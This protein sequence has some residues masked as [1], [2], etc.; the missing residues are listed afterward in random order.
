MAVQRTDHGAI[1]FRA[2]P[3]LAPVQGSFPLLADA[4][5]TTTH[6]HTYTSTSTL[7]TT[8]LIPYPTSSRLSHSPT[9]HG[10]IA[11]RSS[12][13]NLSFSGRRKNSEPTPPTAFY[14]STAKPPHH[15]RNLTSPSPAA[16]T[17]S[18]S[19]DR[20]THSRHY[21]SGNHY[22]AQDPPRVYQSF[23]AA[24]S[25]G[26]LGRSTPYQAHVEP[27]PLDLYGLRNTN[28]LARLQDKLYRP[29]PGQHAY[30]ESAKPPGSNRRLRKS[31]SFLLGSSTSIMNNHTIRQMDKPFP[32]PRNR[33]SDDSSN[34]QKPGRKKSGISQFVKGVL[35]SPRKPEISLPEQPVHLTHVGYDNATGE[36]TVSEYTTHLRLTTID[37]SVPTLL[38]TSTFTDHATLYRVFLRSGNKSLKAVA[39]PKKNKLRTPRPFTTPSRFGS[40]STRTKPI[41]LTTNSRMLA[42][43]QTHSNVIGDRQMPLKAARM[44]MAVDLSLAHRRARGFLRI[45]R[46]ASSTPE[47]RQCLQAQGRPVPQQASNPYRLTVIQ[48]RARRH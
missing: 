39:L 11:L 36:F 48:L 37:S 4:R 28:Q 23:S 35:G 40:K 16:A 20:P 42:L 7:N 22:L 6:T 21:S 18:T 24:Q 29:A 9:S 30:S 19:L 2:R 38:L 25:Q 44:L 34:S 41:K 13:M 15:Q 47:P 3:N 46:V 45:M 8:T 31:T 5:C 33:L 27:P 1:G 26:Y 32:S 14:S 17:S 12:I 10:L 43:R